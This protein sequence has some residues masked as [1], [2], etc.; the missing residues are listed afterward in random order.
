MKKVG[1]TPV[2]VITNG[3]AL[4]SGK[5]AGTGLFPV[6]S[7]TVKATCAAVILKLEEKWELQRTSLKNDKATMFRV[8]STYGV[9][10]PHEAWSAP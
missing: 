1:L 2:M 7:A 8:Q 9:F 6:T 5:L 4:A 10:P 3:K